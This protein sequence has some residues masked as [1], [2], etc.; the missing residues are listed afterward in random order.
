MPER[1][2]GELEGVRQTPLLLRAGRIL[3]PSQGLDTAGAV[4][5][6]DGRVVAIGPEERAAREL[7]RLADE[8]RAPHTVELPA[9]WVL[10]PGFAGLHAHL[11]E[12]GC[13]GKEAIASGAR[14][15]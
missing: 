8:G 1:R 15:A 5:I 9:G 3:D 6:A 4:L 2:P 7:A 11:R 13:E 14:A 12:P 10:T